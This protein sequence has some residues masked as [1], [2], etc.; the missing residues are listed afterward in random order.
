MLC[1]KR[2]LCF[3]S[4]KLVKT[5]AKGFLDEEDLVQINVDKFNSIRILSLRSS[6]TTK[7]TFIFSIKY[8]LK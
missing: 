8:Y 7:L 5:F 4:F 1:I 6:Q 2:L 3:I